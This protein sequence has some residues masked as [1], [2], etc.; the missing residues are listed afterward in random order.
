M[1][2][3]QLSYIVALDTYRNFRKAADKMFITQP[4]LSMQIQKLEQELD[5]VIFDRHILPVEPS[6]IG[7]LIIDQA[8]VILEETARMADIIA[9]QKHQIF[10]TLRIG[11]IPT[12]APYLLPL[13]LEQFLAKYPKVELTI[14][15][16]QTQLIIRH[17]EQSSLDVGIV[18]SPINHPRIIEQT[19]YYE[20][21][22][23]YVARKHRLFSRKRIRTSDLSLNDLWLLKEGHC[24][25]DQILQ[26]CKS[27]LER[28]GNYHFHCHLE[29]ENLETL[30]KLVENNI[31]MT[32]LPRLAVLNLDNTPSNALI[33]EF[34]TPV[35][36]RRISLIYTKALLK[37]R[38]LQVLE[39]EILNALPDGLLN[40][41]DRC[42]VE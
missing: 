19:L 42:V 3:T 18:A 29:G 23:A 41:K 4:T 32:L 2:L 27:T 21:F 17:L 11:I 6:A 34:Y 15:E 10:G 9:S 38:L 40:A 30:R 28:R 35:P 22:V 24:F 31:G 39:Q 7:R 12:V 5:V 8:R 37:R 36:T 14:D 25:R 1:T 20:P 16:L 13:F 26:L 33:R